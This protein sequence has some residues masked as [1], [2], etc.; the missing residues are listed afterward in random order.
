MSR[1]ITV[2]NKDRA[3]DG[4]FKIDRYQLRQEAEGVR[5]DLTRELF[6]RGHAAALLPYDPVLDAV[7][8]VEEF[9]I[10]NLAA[11]LP[12]EQWFSPGP[13]AGMIDEGETP[14]EAAIREGAEEAGL[15]L[16]EAG[17]FSQ[18]TTLPS[19]GGSSETVTLIL[20]LADL[21]GVRP[22]VH[23]EGSE[24][25]MTW[26]RILPREALLDL[27]GTRPTTGHL[28]A[29]AMRLEMLRLS[30]QVPEAHWRARPET[31]T[32]PEV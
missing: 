30:G 28:A 9:R 6:E 11:G 18:I 22:G 24:A 4:F 7:L 1:K 20:A 16:N 25:E 21:S 17:L 12:E 8:V 5:F 26:T 29:L 15:S 2:L 14:V 19:P 3:Y 10:G 27:I 13:I 23:G 31:T 32:E